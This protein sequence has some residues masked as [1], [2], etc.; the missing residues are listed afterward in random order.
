VGEHFGPF[1]TVERAGLA[2]F[3]SDSGSTKDALT[4]SIEATRAARAWWEK[5]TSEP[6]CLRFAPVI[7][8]RFSV[9]GVR[10]R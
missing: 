2:I 6:A 8:E 7:R 4:S 10:L 5:W 1:V 9:V 3:Q